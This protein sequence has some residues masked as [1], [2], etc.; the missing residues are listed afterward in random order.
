MKKSEYF[1][2]ATKAGCHKK[3]AW[4][5]SAFTLTQE[6]PEA[7]KNNPY[8]YRIVQTPT[9]HFFVN[10]Q[11]QLEKI[12]GTEAGV[13]PFKVDDGIKLDTGD[14]PNVSKPIVASLGNILFNLCAIVPAFGNKVEFNNHHTSHERLHYSK[15][16]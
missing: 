3:R 12:D 1:K 16:C 13:P 6:P 7:W 4:V 15:R 2:L 8:Q 14:Y 5:L 9:G 11:Q 10:D